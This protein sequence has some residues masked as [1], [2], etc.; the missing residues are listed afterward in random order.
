MG[1]RDGDTKQVDHQAEVQKWDVGL[2][3]SS[4]SSTSSI[5]SSVTSSSTSVSAAIGAPLQQYVEQPGHKPCEHEERGEVRA[6][7]A[8]RVE[9]SESQR[10][11]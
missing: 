2:S 3:T 4:T 7:E 5:S 1:Q 11:R 6:A 10:V 9:A 8:R